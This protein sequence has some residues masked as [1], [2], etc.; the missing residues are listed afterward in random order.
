VKPAP[1][2]EWRCDA[3]GDACL[4]LNVYA[5]PG[6]PTVLIRRAKMSAARASMLDRP[7]RPGDPVT[8]ALAD[9]HRRGAFGTLAC[10]HD[11]H[12]TASSSTLQDDYDQ[13]VREHRTVRRFLT[14]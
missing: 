4:L 6:G 1:V 8:V 9:L 3:P 14:P 10:R 5:A 7:E 2:V 11:I 13:A 12:L